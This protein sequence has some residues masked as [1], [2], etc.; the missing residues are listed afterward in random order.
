MERI[1]QVLNKN[2]FRNVSPF[3]KECITIDEDNLPEINLVV[4]KPIPRTNNG[5]NSFKLRWANAKINEDI[6]I[7]IIF[8]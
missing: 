5:G 6:K 3:Q 4:A 8:P 7:P 1:Y 2:K